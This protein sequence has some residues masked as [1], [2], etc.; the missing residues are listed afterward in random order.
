MRK[1]TK[2]AGTK[3]I[4]KITQ[5]DTNTSTD[6]VILRER[7]R[8]ERER[9]N[10]NDCL[11]KGEVIL[12]KRLSH[13]A[14]YSQCNL[15]Q[16]LLGE[17]EWVIV[18]SDA[19][20]C[21]VLAGWQACPQDAVVHHVKERTNAVP[22]LVVKPDLEIRC[23]ILVSVTSANKQTKQPEVNYVAWWLSAISL[24]K[25]FIPFVFFCSVLRC[26]SC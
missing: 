7:E 13:W 26:F 15:W 12:L 20:L 21:G 19:K 17:I 14:W 23:E 9:S 11:E 2:L 22:T 6:V 4:A 10:E 25:K 5:M 16:L 8:Q 3:D 1:T 18:G 24:N